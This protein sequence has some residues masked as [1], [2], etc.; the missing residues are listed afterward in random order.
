MTSYP[1]ARFRFWRGYLLVCSAVFTLQAVSWVFIGSFDPF[2]IYDGLLA[3][4][5]YGEDTLPPD[6]QR[7]FQFA[8]APLGATTAGYF[9]LLFA[10]VWGAFPRRE[11]WAWW[12]STIAIAVWFVL[13]S[14]FSIRHGAV[15]NVWL[16]N[17]PCVVILGVALGAL[18]PAFRSDPR[19][20]NKENGT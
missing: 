11:P 13:D 16:V 10:L 1:E 2:G 3:R 4:A 8:V 14:A 19:A 5:L 7:M 6:A 20:A 18:R 17:I 15:F 12:A 9:V